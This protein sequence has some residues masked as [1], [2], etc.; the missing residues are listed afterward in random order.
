MDKQGWMVFGVVSLIWGSTFLAIKVGLADLPPLTFAALRFCVAA[1]CL[2]GYL[3]WRGGMVGVNMQN[4]IHLASL[5]MLMT[6]LPFGLTFWGQQFVNSGL[7]AV[8]TGTVPLF[9]TI[10]AG[11][12]LG[13]RVG[14]ARLMGVMMG[15]AGVGLLF[16]DRMGGAS[17]WLGGLAVVGSSVSYAAGNVYVKRFARHLPADLMNTG[18]TTF[19]AL[20][21]VIAALWWER[22]ADVRLTLTALGAVVY[23]ALMGSALAFGLYFWLLQRAP[24]STVSL[25]GFTIPVVAV[26]LGTTVGEPLTGL[27]AAGMTVILAGVLLAE[28]RCVR[29]PLVGGWHHTINQFRANRR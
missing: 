24:A 21:L 26:V 7:A 1:L 25:V 14:A 9:V 13:E 18:Q 11:P 4:L 29:L 6:A 2:W 17:T 8:L 5:G 20:V 19:G 16:L 23:L 28:G 27:M 15:L 3:A 12:I 10:M 22:G